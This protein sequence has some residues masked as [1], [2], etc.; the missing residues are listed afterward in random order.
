MGGI[1]LEKCAVFTYTI[2]G[3]IIPI[4]EFNK[5]EMKLGDSELWSMIL[6]RG[7]W[8][9]TIILLY[10][11]QHRAKFCAVAHSAQPSSVLWPLA[12]NTKLF[13]LVISA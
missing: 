9:L 5:F 7:P 6:H 12:H 4:K 11:P 8:R 3:L 10:G 1:G 13:V 2:F